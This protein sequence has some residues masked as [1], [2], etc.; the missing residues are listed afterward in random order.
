MDNN[1]VPHYTLYPNKIVV[2]D[3]P[4]SRNYSKKNNLGHKN[5]NDNFNW[6]G[7][8]S[9]NAKKRL[10]F[11][12]SNM[13]FLATEKKISNSKKN[14]SK[15]NQSQLLYKIAFITLTLP[16]KQIH[17]D[18]EIKKIILNQFLIELKQKYKVSNFVWKAEKQE[19]GNI[20]FHILIDKYIHW[21]AIRSIWNRSCNKLG[22]VDRYQQKMLNFFKNGFR[23]S[24]NPND[25]RS[26]EQQK[27]AYKDGLA[28]NFSNPN[29]TDIHAIYKVKNISAYM[30]KYMSKSIT[31]TS[32][33]KKID[34][35]KKLISSIKSNINALHKMLFNSN[36]NDIDKNLILNRI[37]FLNKRIKLIKNI[38]ISMN[39]KGVEG[40]I[41]SQS[42]SLSKIKRYTRAG[43]VEHLPDFDLIQKF[44]SKVFKITSAFSDVFIIYIDIF[45]IDKLRRLY[46]FHI[47]MC[48]SVP[49]IETLA[50]S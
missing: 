23:L 38:I 42:R 4:E 48:Q 49:T 33:S 41:W 29:S 8:L 19:N 45:K 35:A 44:K 30:S 28:N 47:D 39:Y 50:V 25:N 12:L 18:I 27:K 32:Y 31:E 5:L 24:D 11:A 3:L 34:Q 1:L 40:R 26:Y 22:Y 16:S 13:I 17:S 2:Y 9:N 46:Q 21:S 15:A 7:D 20:H 43:F 10:E 36:Q 14:I 37:S 6:S